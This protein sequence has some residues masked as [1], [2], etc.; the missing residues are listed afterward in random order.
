M[1]EKTESDRERKKENYGLCMHV[2]LYV[3]DV[4]QIFRENNK[5]CVCIQRR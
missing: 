4:G 2:R 3:P 1:K 5:A